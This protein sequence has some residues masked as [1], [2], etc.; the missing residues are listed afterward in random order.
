MEIFMESTVEE[1][2]YRGHW[3]DEAVPADEFDVG[4][5]FEGAEY[6][7]HA[8]ALGEQGGLVELE[9]SG[10]GSRTVTLVELHAALGQL[11]RQA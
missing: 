2:E 8:T 1:V 4:F 10:A 7:L 6:E 5:R 3:K 9:V 11:V